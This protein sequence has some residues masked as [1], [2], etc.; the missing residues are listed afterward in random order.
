MP[1]RL[2]ETIVNT[3]YVGGVPLGGEGA[4]PDNHAMSFTDHQVQVSDDA[5]LRPA[6][7]TVEAWVYRDPPN[8]NYAGVLMKGTNGSWADGYGLAQY[9]DGRFGFFI[10]HYANSVVYAPVPVGEWVHVAGTYDGTTI[11]IYVNGELAAN[12]AYTEAIN[13]TTAPLLIGTGAG[14][15]RFK[16]DID[17][18]SVWNVA[19]T[20]AQIQAD[21]AHH[22]AGNE[23]GLV[24][25]WNFDSPTSTTVVDRSP[26]HNDGFIAG[27]MNPAVEEKI[28][29]FQATAGQIL[30]FDRLDLTGATV[31]MR[32][33]DPHGGLIV[34]G[35]FLDDLGPFLA[36][37]TGRYLLVLDG[38]LGNGNTASYS[39]AV[40]TVTDDAGSFTPGALVSG[41]I[42][43][44][45]QTDR[46]TVNI[47]E[48]GLYFFDSYTSNDNLQFRIYDD[49]GNQLD[50]R[51]FRQ[52][53]GGPVFQLA[54]GAYTIRITGNQD[55]TGAYSFRFQSF[56]ANATTISFDTDI[57]GQLA[58]GNGTQVFRFTGTP[59]DV[60]TF[61]VLTGVSANWRLFDAQSNQIFYDSIYDRASFTVKL[62]GEYLLQVQGY[63]DNGAP[64]NYGFRINR[65]DSPAPPAFT[66]DPLTLG[67]SYSG[68]IASADEQDDYVFTLTQRTRLVFDGRVYNGVQWDLDG[69]LGTEVLNRNF[70][71]DNA[72]YSAPGFRNRE[73]LDLGAGTYRIRVHAG[74]TGDYTFRLLD[75]ATAA[76]LVPG[77]T[78]LG[79]IAANSETDLY[80]MTLAANRR[81]Y[82]DNTSPDYYYAANI[83][84]Y[85]PNGHRLADD[86]LGADYELPPAT[87]A[88]EYLIALYGY[89]YNGGPFN[90]TITP[91]KTTETR[92]TLTIDQ[93]ID[94]TVAQPGQ[95]N[96][97]T[98]TLDDT[99]A[100]LFD[101]LTNDTTVRWKLVNADGTLIGLS[102]I[103]DFDNNPRFV[104]A[105]GTY[106]FI[107]D[108]DNA[109]IGS[110]SFR[111]LDITSATE[112]DPGSPVS[113]TLS[114]G[115][116][117]DVYKFNAT[118]GDRF[119]FDVTQGHYGSNWVLYDPLGNQ[120]F[121]EGFNDIDV[122]TLPVGGDYTL[123]IQGY[124]YQTNPVDYTFNVFPTPLSAPIKISSLG[125]TS[126]PDLK[127][128]NIVVAGSPVVESGASVLVSWDD[129][130]RGVRPTDGSSWVDRVTVRREDGEIIANVLA[131][132]NAAL[133]GNGAVGPGD[134][135]HRSVSITLPAGARGAGSLKF[136]VSTDTE[137]AIS[138]ESADSQA[139][140]NNTTSLIVTSVLATYPDLKI[141]DVVATPASGYAPG[142]QV[143]L[144]YT[145]VNDGNKAV[146]ADWTEQVQ[147]R[148]TTTGQTV[149]LLNLSRTAAENGQTSFAAGAT[150]TRQVV[151]TW[152]AGN[153]GLGKFEFAVTAD[154]DGIITEAN[155]AGTGETNNR[156][157]L[158]VLSA[159]DLV[160]QNLIVTNTVVQAGSTLI[161]QWD[162]RN[163]GNAAT[164]ST[165]S[166]RIYIYNYTTSEELL[167]T[168]LSYDPAQAGNGAIAAGASKTRT[169]TFRLPDGLRGAG[170]LRITV[171]ADSTG[172]VVET[173][174]A[175]NGEDN[176]G[177]FLDIVSTPR[178]YAD[179]KADSL[180]APTAGQGGQPLTVDWTVT[181]TSSVTTDAASWKDQIILSRDAIFGNSDD[182]VIG[183]FTHTG[184][185]AGNGS[186][187]EH[188][189]ITLPGQIDGAFYITVRTDALGAVTEPDT[190]AN[191][192]AAASQI[193][194]NSPAA[195]L[196]VEAV[197]GP[198]SAIFGST[199][200]LTWRV[201][202]QN[203]RRPASRTGSIASICRRTMR[204]TAPTSCSQRCRTPALSR[205]AQPIRK[206]LRSSCRTVSPARS[207]CWS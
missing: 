206:P 82:L 158:A 184:A 181:N 55:V 187:T 207:G 94:G 115:N 155:D 95:Q 142:D 192:Y 163:T 84:I 81:L 93:Q 196:L 178:T 50:S 4:N 27:G 12:G 79:S 169:A 124:W 123:I 105:P 150:R 200:N 59:G 121:N 35:R 61:D 77:A 109:W 198:T 78:S 36:Q 70:Y 113:G 116:Q 118:A 188:R 63:I 72:A 161:I 205:T 151:I 172:G 132:Y 13:H 119:F 7:L 73:I 18:A 199:I 11:K 146:T 174:G 31:Y 42:S 111:V 71:D 148:N 159:P 49:S 166:D 149:T 157:V 137:N 34:D 30:Y 104:L 43:E 75:I 5:S 99:K 90:Y 171:T 193:T 32:I 16:G 38:V 164:A 87:V 21:M 44:P 60:L 100:L 129:A 46:Y 136:S 117:S 175:N 1:A 131:P 74:S 26:E 110:Y 17:D 168:T 176:N 186:Y 185:L 194:L 58:P 130:N 135:R 66:G 202:N 183:E 107:V 10:N 114:P 156:T 45:G 3:I 122:R 144:S 51:N 127:V 57:A 190:L 147:V 170:N 54:A 128:E 197:A 165:F 195:D 92:A 98:F 69:P 25:Y 133:P 37:A 91:Y 177:A 2:S 125:F 68:S 76:A 101:G 86:Y 102:R 140:I 134:T 191:N 39:F 67:A 8:G 40:R 154:A 33:Y 143:T 180:V 65:V 126:S 108:P 160:V 88:G 23:A 189:T 179:L 41:N 89:N 167:N 47:T 97:F 19:L 80:K 24:G 145:I 182:I 52:D 141:T 96:R 204:S 106:T 139:E 20:Q 203:I 83:R 173:N 153:T 6:S 85:D 152:P 22:L 201:R 9:P 120:L 28:Y 14:N 48:A 162:D 112:I 56:G 15:Y 62:P 64:V 29:S 53:V 103:Y 138:E